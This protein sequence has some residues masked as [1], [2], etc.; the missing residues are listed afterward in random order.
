MDVLQLDKV[1][2]EARSRAML[3]T[4]LRVVKPVIE[5]VCVVRHHFVLYGAYHASCVD[6]Y[7]EKGWADQYPRAC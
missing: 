5:V 4:F 7:C 6:A 3:R 1:F 2:F